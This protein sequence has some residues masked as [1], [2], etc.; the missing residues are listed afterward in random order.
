MRC[1]QCESLAGIS[2]P[3]LLSL[4]GAAPLLRAQIS[5]FQGRAAVSLVHGE[6]RRRNV[7]NALVAIDDQVR[8]RPQA[9]EIRAAQAQYCCGQ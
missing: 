9:Q 1:N 4:A 8:P 3:A 6:D 5:S 2:R 7:Y